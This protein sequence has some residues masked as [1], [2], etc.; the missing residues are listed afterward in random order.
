MTVPFGDCGG[1]DQTIN[2]FIRVWLSDGCGCGIPECS[3]MDRL[4]FVGLPLLVW[5]RRSVQVEN[6]RRLSLELLLCWK[7]WPGIGSLRVVCWY[8]RRRFLGVLLCGMVSY[9]VWRRVVVGRL[10]EDPVGVDVVSNYKDAVHLLLICEKQSRKQ[11]RLIYKDPTR[12]LL[13]FPVYL[14]RTNWNV[15]RASWG[16]DLSKAGHM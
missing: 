4:D 15:V 13:M 6:G 11:R 3:C 2:R 12:D 14:V 1:I 7:R 8:S 5:K 10:P 9:E 16:H